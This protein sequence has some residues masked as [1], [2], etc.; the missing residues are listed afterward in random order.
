MRER[1]ERETGIH[2]LSRGEESEL[3]KVT[4]LGGC[5][6]APPTHHAAWTSGLGERLQR[7]IRASEGKEEENRPYGREERGVW[8]LKPLSLDPSPFSSLPRHLSLRCAAS[9]LSSPHLKRSGP[10]L[11]S[12]SKSRCSLHS[13]QTD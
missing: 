8:K 10:S 7:R 3:S 5:A 2:R 12:S 13:L 6:V 9:F 1:G 4:I 11:F